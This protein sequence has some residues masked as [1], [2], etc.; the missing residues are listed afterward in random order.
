LDAEADS[1][2]NHA[3]EDKTL[4]HRTRNEGDVLGLQNLIQTIGDNTITN[5]YTYDTVRVGLIPIPISLLRDRV[6]F[7]SK[8]REKLWNYL[9]GE[10]IFLQA[11]KFGDKIDYEHFVTNR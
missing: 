2:G 10:L 9:T 1:E 11:S 6:S 4:I 3:F 8:T 5:V 7:C